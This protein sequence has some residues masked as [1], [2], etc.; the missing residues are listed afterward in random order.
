ML[1]PRDL[2]PVGNVSFLG[3]T[4]EWVAYL[5]DTCGLTPAQLGATSWTAVLPS[6]VGGMPGASLEQ[7]RLYYHSLRFVSWSSSRYI[8]QATKDLEAELE[9]GAAIYINWNNMGAHWYY[10]T[11]TPAAVPPNP[12]SG[13]LNHDWFEFARERGAT[14]LWTEDWF[15][16][17]LSW[18]WSYYAALMSAYTRE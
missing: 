9:P 4:T 13:Q 15:G 17:G 5:R 6:T 8:A 10:P 11:T 7:R 18:Q 16:D 1:I 12:A 14:M 3:V 2:P